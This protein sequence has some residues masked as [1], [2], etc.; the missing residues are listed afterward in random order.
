LTIINEASDFHERLL[1]QLQHVYIC[2]QIVYLYAMNI[3][4]GQFRYKRRIP[5]ICATCMDSSE[6]QGEQAVVYQ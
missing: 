3:I 1:F 6:L 5:P 2:T 4:S